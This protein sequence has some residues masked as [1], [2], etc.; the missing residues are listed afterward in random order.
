MLDALKLPKETE[1][2][3]KIRS[4][5]IQ[6][7]YKYAL[8]VPLGTARTLNNILNNLDLFVK[9]GTVSAITDVGCSILF[10]SSAI[11]AALFNVTINLKSLKDED[12]RSKV[13]KETHDLIENAHRL[14]DKYLEETYNRLK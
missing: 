8:E 13:E 10:V 14:R 12:F 9:Y 5:K 11:E 7:G 3:K 2:E 6:D 4:E 1:E